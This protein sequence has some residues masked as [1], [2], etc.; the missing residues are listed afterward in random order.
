MKV[1]TVHRGA[2]DE[3]QVACALHEAGILESLVT[4]LY[5]PADSVWAK[6]AERATPARLRRKLLNRSSEA[7][8]GRAVRTCW[9]TGSLALMCDGMPSLPFRLKRASMRACDR[10]LGKRAAETASR[11]DAALLSYS[12]YAHSAFS[13]FHGK[14]PRILFQLHPHPASVRAILLRERELHPECSGSLNKEWELA[15]PEHDFQ[16]LVQE[17]SMPDF[18][19]AA[20]S[21]TKATLVEYGAPPERVQVI[22]YGTDLDRF[23]PGKLRNSVKRPLRL[24]FVGT[25]C[26]RKGL[27]YL[28]DALES[29]PSGAAE[30]TICGR[31]VDDAAILGRTRAHVHLRSFVS[32]EELLREF[33]SSDIFVFPSLVEGFGHVLLEA[34]ACGLPVIGTTRTAAPDLISD[35]R[36]GL[37]IEPGHTAELVKCLEYFLNNPERVTQMSAAALARAEEFTWGKFRHR[38]AETVNE[39]ISLR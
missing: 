16:T 15:L 32:P 11:T 31:M 12:Y 25:V 23:T 19:I 34:M 35:G 27:S 20:S 37:I 4:D 2:R 8:P 28:L 17:C 30:L 21:F 18:W 13:H 22:P 7:L 26:Q 24:L 3:Y 5:W 39:M 36:E 33:Q 10:Q 14:R 6:A 9:A 38:V 29:L 1:V